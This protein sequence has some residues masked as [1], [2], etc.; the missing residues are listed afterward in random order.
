VLHINLQLSRLKLPI[1]QSVS[2][3]LITS[4]STRSDS[5]IVHARNVSK[6]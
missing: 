1:T 2:I 5:F 3:I 4:E 6:V